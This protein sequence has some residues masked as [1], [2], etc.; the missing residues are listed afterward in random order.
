MWSS[1]L[2]SKLFRVLNSL[3][4]VLFLITT[5][6]YAVDTLY[7]LGTGG[8]GAWDL[9]S[10][11]W[12]LTSGGLPNTPWVNGDDANLPAFATLSNITVDTGGISVEN[13][14]VNN[15]S[16][17]GTS[18][19]ILGG[20]ITLTGTTP[21][22]V[23]SSTGS[24]WDGVR[25][26]SVISGSVGLQKDGGGFIDLYGANTYTGVTNIKAGYV[27]LFN[28]TSL[29]S[30]AG[31]AADGT[32]VQSGAGLFCWQNRTITGEY[33]TLNGS[34]DGTNMAIRVGGNARLTWNAPV[35]L[36]SDTSI[37]TDSG[38]TF[39]FGSTI[40]GAAV[41]ANFTVNLDGPQ[42]NVH[43]FNGNIT[44]G[45]GSLNK[46]LAGTMQLTGL[47]NNWGRFLDQ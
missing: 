5:A 1:V 45:S 28:D 12:T 33:L 3:L 30:S 26:D 22:I 20:P 36:G 11:N 17:L 21:T 16:G 47:A 38:S 18:Y 32:V 42:A 10:N 24:I 13:I 7:W 2:G 46:N 43:Y 31:G 40:D 9:T 15:T 4:I 19:D 6:S 34:G 37:M 29:G 23:S 8:P 39:T 35:T 41:N 25:I 44:L 27:T 14:T